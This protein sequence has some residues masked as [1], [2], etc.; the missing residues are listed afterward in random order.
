MDYLIVYY[1]VA[2][3]EFI[4]VHKKVAYV[5]MDAIVAEKMNAARNHYIKSF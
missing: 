3:G 5:R 2:T 4:V 1:L